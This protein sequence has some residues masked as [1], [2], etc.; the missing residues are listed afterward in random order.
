MTRS[1]SVRWVA[2][3]ISALLVLVALAPA[4]PGLALI[5]SMRLVSPHRV[6]VG[7][8]TSTMSTSSKA[9]NRQTQCWR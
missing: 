4:L 9:E 7:M 5:T 6:V 1:L 3:A 2:A 8:P